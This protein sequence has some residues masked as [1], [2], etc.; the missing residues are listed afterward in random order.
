[1]ELCVV[2]HQW[3]RGVQLECVKQAPFLWQDCWTSKSQSTDKRSCPGKCLPSKKQS[4]ANIQFTWKLLDTIFCCCIYARVWNINSEDKVPK[5][6]KRTTHLKTHHP[7]CTQEIRHI[8][9]SK[10]QTNEDV[11]VCRI[12]EICVHLQIGSICEKKQMRECLECESRDSEE[13]KYFSGK[14]QYCLEMTSRVK[15]FIAFLRSAVLT[16]SRR[17]QRVSSEV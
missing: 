11:P 17:T 2:F 8:F 7:S 15:E 10:P 14:W 1:M 6:Y 3:E 12:V 16:S 5:F 4:I 9:L 13:A